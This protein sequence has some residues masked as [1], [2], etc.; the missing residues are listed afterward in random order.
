LCIRYTILQIL[1]SEGTV[2]QT[3]CEGLREVKD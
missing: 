2:M 3:L 1:S